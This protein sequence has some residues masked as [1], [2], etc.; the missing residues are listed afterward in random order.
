MRQSR[1]GDQKL[2]N[3]CGR[4]SLW[5]LLA[6]TPLY[7]QQSFKDFKK[8][9]VESF[10]S[11]KDERDSAFEKYLKGEWKA[12]SEQKPTPL[13]EEPKPLE[14]APAAPQAQNPVGPKIYLPAKE[15]TNESVI[16]EIKPQIIKQKA[17][18]K[19]VV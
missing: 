13:Y 14:I 4:F 7:A 15:D 1:G 2:F 9:Q 11:Y 10:K 8:V 17:D 12:F 16:V 3:L 19:S 6:L 18:R 5:L